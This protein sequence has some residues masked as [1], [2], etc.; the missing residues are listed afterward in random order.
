MPIR[1]PRLDR[2]IR[3]HSLGESSF[4]DSLPILALLFFFGVTSLPA[5]A[6]ASSISLGA[7]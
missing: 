4:Y 1:L 5:F 6:Q 3:V 2:P 7:G